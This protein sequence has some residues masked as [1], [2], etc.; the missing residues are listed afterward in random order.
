MTHK[1]G[2]FVCTNLVSPLF[3]SYLYQTP[4][5]LSQG[6][7][8][9]K[10]AQDHQSSTTPRETGYKCQKPSNPCHVTY[11]PLT[12]TTKHFQPQPKHFT[13]T[14]Q[15]YHSLLLHSRPQKHFTILPNNK[16]RHRIRSTISPTKFPISMY[17][18]LDTRSR[19]FSNLEVVARVIENLE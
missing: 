19:S 2:T 9:R 5:S 13:T 16:P 15:P 7:H 8:N 4:K 12:P 10:S 6:V 14:V 3:K 18:Q 1:D 17:H 11:T